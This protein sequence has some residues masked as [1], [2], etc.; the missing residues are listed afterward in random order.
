MLT[1]NNVIGLLA[2]QFTMNHSY[3]KNIIKILSN[4]YKIKIIGNNE[5]VKIS[6]RKMRGQ[7]CY[8]KSI[9]KILELFLNL[10]NIPNT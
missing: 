6:E 4:T 5:L 8:M 3:I 1:K 7:F 9:K 10:N 2:T